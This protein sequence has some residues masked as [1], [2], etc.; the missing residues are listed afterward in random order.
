[1]TKKKTTETKS[2]HYANYQNFGRPIEWTPERIEE[3]FQA[4]QEWIFDDENIFY[5]QFAH[6][7]G[8]DK[9]TFRDIAQ[10]HPDFWRV[11][12]IAKEMQPE[13]IQDGALKQRYNGNFAQFILRCKFGFREPK[14]DN[15]QT[16]IV[17]ELQAMRR[18]MNRL[19]ENNPETF[20]PK[21]D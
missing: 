21:A 12:K 8:Y 3:E 1:M 20:Q 4:F 17:G 9:D 7:R 14:D 11:Y 6:Q 18:D 2:K 13:K 5:Y 16:E 15:P 10:K 19:Y